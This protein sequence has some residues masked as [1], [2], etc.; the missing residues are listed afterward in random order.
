MCIYVYCIYN[1][2]DQIFQ[3]AAGFFSDA[4]F[5]ACFPCPPGSFSEVAQPAQEKTD[6]VVSCF[7][8]D[9]RY[10]FLFPFVLFLFLHSEFIN[11]FFLFLRQFCVCVFFF[12]LFLFS[13]QIC[14]PSA[15]SVNMKAEPN[16]W[17][18]IYIYNVDWG[19]PNHTLVATG[20]LRPPQQ[21]SLPLQRSPALSCLFHLASGPATSNEGRPRPTMHRRM[22]SKPPDLRRRFERHAEQASGVGSHFANH[23]PN[24]V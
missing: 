5:G 12:R 2:I 21:S 23:T 10:P 11:S 18:Y 3:G 4:G 20:L 15:P 14:F 6:A 1:S 22:R 9:K 16:S 7:F 24:K 13:L 8:H 17:I 19:F